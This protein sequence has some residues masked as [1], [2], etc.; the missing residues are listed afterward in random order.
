MRGQFNNFQQ[1]VLRLRMRLSEAISCIPGLAKAELISSRNQHMAR[2]WE[3][4]QNFERWGRPIDWFSKNV[5]SSTRSKGEAWYEAW[6][7]DGWC[8]KKNSQVQRLKSNQMYPILF[9]KLMQ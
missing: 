3:L 5:Y 4:T 2:F 7:A 1:C 8:E 9:D 6:N